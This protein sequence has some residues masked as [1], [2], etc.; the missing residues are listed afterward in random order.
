MS[1]YSRSV[2][3]YGSACCQELRDE[4]SRSLKDKFDLDNDL[5]L[6]NFSDGEYKS[7]IEE[8]IRG[9][10]VYI[11]QPTSMPTDNL[12]KLLMSIDAAKRSSA[13]EVNA[14]IP[15]FGFARQDQKL[16]SR[17]SITAQLVAKF[18]ETSGATRAICLDLHAGQIQGFFP[19][20]PCDNLT[21][22]PIFA[23]RI[24]EMFSEEEMKSICFVA[25]DVGEAKN[26]LK[27]SKIFQKPLVICSKERDPINPDIINGVTVIGDVKDKH[28]VIIDDLT[29]TMGTI[30]S[31][32]NQL[33]KA[34]SK[35]IYF[36]CTHFACSPETVEKIKKPVGEIG[37]ERLVTTNSHPN[38]KLSYQ[39]GFEVINLGSFLAEVISRIEENRSLSELFDINN[40]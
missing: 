5:L 20:I 7:K 27:M 11:V 37:F 4:M 6:T 39:I 14:V 31:V 26:V 40:F 9:R 21:A 10:K 15:Y 34:G 16:E 30:I 18:I 19:N 25:P 17:E 29:S 22:R 13:K 32:A 8:N 1:E 33:K 12:F 28:C 2:I 24:Q 3:L 23:K 35:S 38:S 36:F